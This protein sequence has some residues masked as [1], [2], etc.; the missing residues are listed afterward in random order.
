MCAG[1][2][3]PCDPF[4]PS[5]SSSFTFSSTSVSVIDVRRMCVSYSGAEESY[6]DRERMKEAVKNK[7]FSET[8]KVESTESAAMNGSITVLVLY[9][10]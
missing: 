6:A 3:K 2:R 5:G 1:P 9:F 7:T 10:F 8:I 4:K